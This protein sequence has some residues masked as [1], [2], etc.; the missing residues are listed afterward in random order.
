MRKLRW[1]AFRKTPGRTC[2]HLHQTKKAA[3]ECMRRQERKYG[4]NWYVGSAYYSH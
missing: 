3:E 4:G 1:T 2:G